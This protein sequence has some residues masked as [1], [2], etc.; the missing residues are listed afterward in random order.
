LRDFSPKYSARFT[1]KINKIL[2]WLMWQLENAVS[3][4]KQSFATR[5]LTVICVVFF[6]YSVLAVKLYDTVF[7]ENSTKIITSDGNRITKRADIYDRNGTLLA[8]DLT[9][10]SVYANPQIVLDPKEAASKLAKS[11]GLDHNKLLKDFTSNKKFIWIKRN[12][13][14]KEHYA[15]NSLGIP[16]VFFEQGYKRV[17]PHSNLFA[18]VLG[19]V[20]LDGKGLAGIEQYFQEHLTVAGKNKE[21]QN[22]NLSLDLRLQHILHDELQAS[23]DEFSAVGAAGVIA[24]VNNGEIIAM[25]S[26]PDFDPH[27]LTGATQDALFNRIS[28]FSQE[29]G[30]SFKTITMAMALDSKKVRFN[31]SFDVSDPIKVAN[32][33]LRDYHRREGA[34]SVPE[35]F[36]F[37]SN[38]GTAKMAMEVGSK[39]QREFLQKLGLLDVL[40]IEIPERAAPQFP[41]VERW[42]SLST[43]TISYG[44]GIAVTPLH[45]ARAY[46]AL[47]NGGNLMDLTLIKDKQSKTQ[48]IISKETSEQVAKLLRLV[49]TSGTGRKAAVPGYVVGGKTGSA[50]KPAKGGYNRKA[51]ISSFV[52]IFPANDPKYVVLTIMDEPKGTKKTAGFK[53]GGWTAAP[54]VGRIIARAAP[55]LGVKPVDEKDEKIIKKM[56]INFPGAEQIGSF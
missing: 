54:A 52:S 2:F 49:V 41:P 39:S 28:M 17:Y 30:S 20:G 38:I 12:L 16:G 14:P 42:G 32:F 33:R 56:W 27:N 5:V 47:V 15:V 21:P 11:L 44:H 3:P 7:A 50:D 46:A 9:T 26:L 8:V 35:I 53:T 22:L 45:M 6:A 23:V 18:H 19:Y 1:H 37:S 43:M 51:I 34:L 31:D 40:N 24:D 25:V 29:M 55:I 13:T 4:N 10:Y 48:K 36:M